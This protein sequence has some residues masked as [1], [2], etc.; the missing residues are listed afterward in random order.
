VARV[1]ELRASGRTYAASYT[2]VAGRIHLSESYVKR[3]YLANRAAP[4]AASS[5]AANWPEA[6]A[7]LRRTTDE[8]LVT[9]ERPGVDLS[10]PK[11]ATA[12]A[13]AR[14]LDVL[15][16]RLEE[17]GKASPRPDDTEAQI[18]ALRDSTLSG[19][20]RW[21]DGRLEL[22]GVLVVQTSQD[23]AGVARP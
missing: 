3:T 22:V 13:C 5:R 14:E 4:A 6:L 23:D 21:V 16:A 19:D 12:L 8:L 10:K 1:E 15:V 2:E 17:A 9:L 18:R 11:N 7:N 20:W